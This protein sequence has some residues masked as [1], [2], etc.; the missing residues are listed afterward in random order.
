MANPT[1]QSRSILGILAPALIDNE[2][3]TLT[4]DLTG[5]LAGTRLD[6]APPRSIKDML[7]R[8]VVEESPGR[9]NV[10]VRARD[11]LDANG[12]ATQDVND[13][14]IQ[15]L[16][17]RDDQQQLTDEP[18]NINLSAGAGQVTVTIG[19][20]DAVS[21][22]INPFT[23]AQ[24]VTLKITSITDSTATVTI[25]GNAA[26]AASTHEK[27]YKNGA[28]VYLLAVTGAAGDG[29]V[30]LGIED[31]EGNGL[32]SSDDAAVTLNV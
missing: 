25:D 28:A 10:R 11:V 21:V 7:R 4:L 27:N 26:P 14:L 15:Y 17:E 3:G 16:Q 32:D 30:N 13:K 23:A 2:D 5:T 19:V 9:L 24:S 6:E 31:S 1:G 12:N 8:L 22:A 29:V 20:T 18:Y